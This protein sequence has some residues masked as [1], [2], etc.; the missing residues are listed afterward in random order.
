MRTYYCPI[1]DIECPYCVGIDYECVIDDP[2]T[3]CDDYYACCGEDE[4][5]EDDS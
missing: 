4:E 3:E 2:M 1:R 5:E